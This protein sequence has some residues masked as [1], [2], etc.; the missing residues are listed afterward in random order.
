[1]LDDFFQYATELQQSLEQQGGPDVV[2]LDCRANG[3]TACVCTGAD[4]W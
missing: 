1:M 2:V 4:H 3:A